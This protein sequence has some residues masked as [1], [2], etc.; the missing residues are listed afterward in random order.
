M[1]DREFE[2]ADDITGVNHARDV[3][4]VD[5]DANAAEIEAAFRAKTERATGEDYWKFV[6]AR[7]VA[8]FEAVP[9]GSAVYT[10]LRTDPEPGAITSLAQ[11][12]E[13]LQA[14][15]MSPAQT[16]TT[17]YNRIIRRTHSEV[18]DRLE[19]LVAREDSPVTHQTRQAVRVC[20]HALRF[21]DLQKGQRWVTGPT[22]DAD[23]SDGLLTGWKY[24][25]DCDRDVEYYSSTETGLLITVEP[26]D[27]LAGGEYEVSR[28][29]NGTRTEATTHPRYGNAKRQVRR[30]ILEAAP[31]D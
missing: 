21:Q 26:T 14:Q 10:V 29:Q 4:D 20:Y 16:G 13:V 7:E 30:W 24:S 2:T 23:A 15:K 22:S 8:L 6:K 31:S 3:L 11:A 18:Q 5:R 9:T 1:A 12:E 17:S 28:L 25:I 27:D 19:E